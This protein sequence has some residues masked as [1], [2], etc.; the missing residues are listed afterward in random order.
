MG[1]GWGIAPIH[2]V[3]QAGK[4]TVVLIDA[5]HK[6]ALGFGS[7][8]QLEE[9]RPEALIKDISHE[10]HAIDTAGFKTLFLKISISAAGVV[11]MVGHSC[12]DTACRDFL[13]PWRL[14][15]AGYRLH[16]PLPLLLCCRLRQCRLPSQPHSFGPSHHPPATVITPSRQSRQTDCPTRS[17]RQHCQRV[18]TGSGTQCSH[19]APR[20]FLVTAEV[21]FPNWVCPSRSQPVRKTGRVSG[22]VC[23]PWRRRSGFPS[24]LLSHRRV[25][26][27]AVPPGQ[28]PPP[29]SWLGQCSGETPF[30]SSSPAPSEAMISSFSTMAPQSGT[31]R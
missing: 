2:P 18:G 26:G 15:G 12:S 16:S 1:E 24:A 6:L 22:S 20:D 14:P 31:S 3:L 17:R 10:L 30:R 21:Q 9:V 11:H 8:S 4:S 28:S 23:P 25:P 5:V 13:R 7:S 27:R 29:S 19:R